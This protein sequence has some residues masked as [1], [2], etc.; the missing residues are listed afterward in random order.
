MFKAVLFDL[1]GTLLNRDKSIE[2]FINQQYERLF[3]LLSHISKEQYISRFIELDNRGYVWKDKV[4]QQLIDEFNIS[5]VTCEELLKDYLKE[6]KHHCVGFPHIHEM[7]E[8]LKNN[9]I[10]LG[11]ITNGYGQFQMEN[12]KALNIDQYFDV[13]L[14]SEWEGMKKPNPQIF[15]N[16]LEKLNVEPSESV[17]IGDHPENDVKAAQNVGMK[18]IWKRDNQWTDIEADAII[19][20][21]L[22][23]PEILKKLDF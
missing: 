21:Y 6:F 3:D 20:D 17:F 12:I 16:A 10:A 22:K 7:L 9:K 5:S 8:E 13:I 2:L 11:M 15:I 19:D 4:Y 23:L 18:G 14:V 1:D